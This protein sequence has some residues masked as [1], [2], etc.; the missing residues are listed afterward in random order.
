MKAISKLKIDSTYY[1]IKDEKTR[2]EVESLKD[3]NTTQDSKI[4][5][6]AS[7]SP[8]VASSVSEMTDTTKVYV[9]TTDGHWYYYNGIEWVDGGVY[10]S[11]QIED[12]S[13]DLKMLSEEVV[14][15]QNS[16]NKLN[17]L[18]C[19]D[20]SSP[21]STSG[22]ILD[23]ETY[24][25]TDYILLSPNTNYETLYCKDLKDRIGSLELPNRCYYYDENKTY[26]NS[27]PTSLPK[28]ESDN[29]V[30]VIL[31]FNKTNVPFEDRF[32][33]MLYN[34]TLYPV[35]PPFEQYNRIN[36][37]NFNL[38]INDYDLSKDLL[39]R[40]DNL[41]TF[42]TEIGTISSENGS[43]V[44]STTR[45]RTI[46]YEYLKKYTSFELLSDNVKIF[47]FKYN[48]DFTLDFKTGALTTDYTIPEDGYYRILFA[49]TDDREITEENKV[50]LMNLYKITGNVDNIYNLLLKNNLI[51]STNEKTYLKYS[52]EKIDLHS[53]Y[54][55]NQDFKNS[56]QDSCIYNNY[57]FSFDSTG[58]FKVYNTKTKETISD[59][60]LGEYA[61]IK[62]HCNA[63][64]FGNEF[65]DVNDK[66][67]L[68]YV[69]AYNNTD[70]PKGTCYVHRVVET[71]IGFTTS[72]VQT[73]SIGFTTD[74]IWTISG[75]ERPYGNFIVDT[76]NNYLYVF[77]LRGDKTRF[78]KFNLPT[79]SDGSSVV[80]STDDIIEYFDVPF[81][82][83]IQGAL[84]FNNKIYSLNGNNGTIQ[85]SSALNVIDL[86]KKEIVTNVNLS[87]MTSEPEAIVIIDNQLYIA[88]VNQW[89][90]KLVV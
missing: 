34:S 43:C 69:N 44:S 19:V 78:F 49:F 25:R 57:I 48:D 50:E 56:V 33:V 72:L 22:E 40:F 89:F 68:L 21:K 38:N 73:I 70:L 27:T 62:P 14:K 28:N 77:T 53:M 84:Y 61:T 2:K 13:I 74:E 45:L 55:E 37:D 64:C 41:P 71:E 24:W 32:K 65:Y 60:E 16:Y 18:T 8:L 10:Q 52:G 58:K 79:L 86:Y 6:L 29:Y 42:D 1:E 4:R 82:P 47:I 12:K 75:D 85:G 15:N 36:N 5:S 23:N 30:Y 81:M 20:N 26:I 3:Y 87:L 9:N 17:P 46:N 88:G 66:F 83:F 54:F 80:L 63:V 67:P 90:K 59:C 11:T 7:G 76:D 35:R 39:K 51:E 31:S